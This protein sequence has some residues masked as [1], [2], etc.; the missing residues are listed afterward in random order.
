MGPA[1]DRLAQCRLG[2]LLPLT[3][4]FIQRAPNHAGVRLFSVADRAGLVDF[5]VR[6]A[7]I[8]RAWRFFCG[9]AT[10]FVRA[11]NLSP[12]LRRVVFVSQPP[13]G[14]GLDLQRVRLNPVRRGYQ[15]VMRVLRFLKAGGWRIWAGRGEGV[16][17]TDSL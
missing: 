3:E 15:V 6:E 11:A 5:F 7:N 10:P 13:L 16:G 2:R 17:S 8:W 12:L 1:G 9:S 14:E 4:L